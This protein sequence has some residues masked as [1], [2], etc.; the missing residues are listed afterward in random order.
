M[1][2]G[3]MKDTQAGVVMKWTNS[4]PSVSNTLSFEMDADFF[5]DLCL[6]PK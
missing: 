3:G 4:I 1:V 6:P 2:P 5:G